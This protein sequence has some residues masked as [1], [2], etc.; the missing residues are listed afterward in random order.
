LSKV[1]I[2]STDST[3]S[4]FIVDFIKANELPQ[5]VLGFSDLF[6]KHNRT[7][8]EMNLTVERQKQR[9]ALKKEETT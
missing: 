6:K 2:A 7:V 3:W 5:K 9:F 1:F 4:D 8:I